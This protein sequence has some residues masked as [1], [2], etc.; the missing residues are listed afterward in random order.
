MLESENH[1]QIQL[2]GMSIGDLKKMARVG[3]AKT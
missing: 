2:R 1:S 3:L